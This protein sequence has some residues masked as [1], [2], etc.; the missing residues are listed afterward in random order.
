MKKF[1]LIISVIALIAGILFGLKGEE[2]TNSD[3]AE[4]NINSKPVQYVMLLSLDDRLLA[5]GQR[6]RDKEIIQLAFEQFE[7]VAK[8]HLLINSKDRFLVCIAPQK[9]NDSNVK[10]LAQSLCFDLPK[11]A[12]KDRV[13]T[14]NDFKSTLSTKIDNLYNA[15]YKG[16][17]SSLY[18]GSNIW[19]LFNE[20]LPEI[21][22]EQ[23]DT[24]VILLCDGYFDFEK[25]N[26][27]LKRGNR[28]TKSDEIFETF[29][30]KEDGIEQMRRE[31][32]GILQVSKAFPFVQVCVAELL[33][34]HDD[35]MES[36]ILTY[37]WQDWL[38]ANGMNEPKI[39]LSGIPAV[40]HPR[41]QLFLNS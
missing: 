4:L 1:I 21:S 34:K 22:N 32:Y 18:D 27:E 31:D 33:P 13:A 23:V 12:A 35:Q 28:S 5:P 14:L 6:E 10:S 25:G 8:G 15:A 39:I 20:T 2:T 26:G 17:N 11:I 7:K 16:D 37:I 38:T 40:T 3:N 19:K 24:K 30:G 41:I 9:G 29:R 36:D